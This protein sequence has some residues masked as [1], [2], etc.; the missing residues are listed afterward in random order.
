MET[1]IIESKLH[2][3]HL[4]K[5]Y[6]FHTTFHLSLCLHSY[7]VNSGADPGFTISRGVN[8]QRGRRPPTKSLFGDIKELGPVGTGS[9]LYI[10]PLLKLNGRM[11]FCLSLEYT[12]TD[13]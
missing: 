4:K 9:F 1:E 7:A 6:N 11:S 10:D 5:L 3:S 8:H 2:V 13:N 12:N